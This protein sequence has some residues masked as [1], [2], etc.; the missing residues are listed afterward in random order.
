MA[1]RATK[2]LTRIIVTRKEFHQKSILKTWSNLPY[3]GFIHNVYVR[4]YINFAN[5]I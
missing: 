4:A 2:Q 3:T 5:K 1:F